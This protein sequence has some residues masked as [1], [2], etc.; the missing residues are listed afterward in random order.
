[1]MSLLNRPADLMN[2]DHNSLACRPITASDYALSPPNI[3]IV[4]NAEHLAGADD[5]FKALRVNVAEASSLSE[6]CASCF[7]KRD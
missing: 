6:C 3:A 2:Y 5:A 7:P 1:M 4:G